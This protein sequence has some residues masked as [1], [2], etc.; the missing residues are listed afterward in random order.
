MQR[1]SKH[2]SSLDYAVTWL[3]RT[4]SDH[5]DNHQINTRFKSGILFYL[6]YNLKLMRRLMQSKPSIVYAVDLDTLLAARLYQIRHECKIVFDS[7]EY[8]SEVP[9]LNGKPL[10]KKIWSAIGKWGITDETSCI[11]VNQSLSEIL[12][13]KYD[14]EF[15]VLRNVPLKQHQENNPDDVVADK[16]IILYLGAVNEGR[17]LEIACQAFAEALVGPEYRLWIIGDGDIL[18]N[19]KAQYGNVHSIIFHGWV[20]PKDLARLLN[21]AYLGINMLDAVSMSYYY[22]LTNKYFDYINHRLPALHMDYPEYQTLQASHAVAYLVSEYSVN[23]L[24]SGIKHY[25]DPSEYKKSKLACEKASL[26]FNWESES[27]KLTQIMEQIA[28]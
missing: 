26:D 7:H 3:C 2:L 18:S 9:E 15:H 1:I 20:K 28:T 6:E 27:D 22:S 5:G 25:E 12:S 24:L 8:F 14:Q 23:G 17:G 19:L 11:T 13:Q 21:Q 16:K 4:T 10:K